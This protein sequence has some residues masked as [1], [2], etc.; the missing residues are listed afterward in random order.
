V[1]LIFTEH[2][3]FD[4]SD[5][6][7]EYIAD[8]LRCISPRGPGFFV[9]TATNGSYVQTTGAR[10]KLTVELR[11][12]GNNNFRHFVLGNADVTDVSTRQ[13]NSAS[14]QI[15]LLANEVLDADD[16]IEIFQCFLETEGIPERFSQRDDTQR[17][18][19]PECDEPSD[20]RESP[21]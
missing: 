19:A 8:R 7:Q 1:T 3:H 12:Q 13:I 9:L 21:S 6:T 16:A 18:D 17:F 15:N 11:R 2:N 20:A 14:G 5:P 4:V 10:L